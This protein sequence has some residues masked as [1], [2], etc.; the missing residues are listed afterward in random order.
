MS[1]RVLIA[2]EMGANLGHLLRDLAVAMRLR[3]NGYEVLFAVRD[4]K[5]A[6]ECLAEEGFPYVAAPRPARVGR[7]FRPAAN[8]SEMLIEYGYLDLTLLAGLVREWRE[9]FAL[10]RP[11]AIVIDHAPTALIAA[12]VEMIPAILLGTGFEIPPSISPLPSIQPGEP[13]PIQQ[14]EAS[15]HRA[16]EAINSILRSYGRRPLDRPASLFSSVQGLLTTFPEL[17]H[18]G[19]RTDREYIGVLQVSQPFPCVDWPHDTG[20]K[21]FAYVRPGLTDVEALLSA[22]SDLALSA[23]CVIPEIPE[24]LRKRFQTARLRLLASVVNPSPLLASASAVVNYGGAGTIATS[25]LAGVPM[26]L[27]PRTLEQHMGALAVKRLGA[28]IIVSPRAD[29]TLVSQL[30]ETLLKNAEYRVAANAFAQRNRDFDSVRALERVTRRVEE[31][32]TNY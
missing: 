26:L 20:P 14:L 31:V 22:F 30:L 2:W 12:R 25:L 6:E 21:V 10:F 15:D 17:D 8:Y 7:P 27:A 18:Y 24:E 16:L 32:A 13:I 9:L 11:A 5:L 19:E 1:R 28:G 29:R 4:A 3:Q 23:I